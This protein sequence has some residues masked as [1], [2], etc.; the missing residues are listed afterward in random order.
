MTASEYSASRCPP[1]AAA[2]ISA[3]PDPRLPRQ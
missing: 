1:T 2:A 3:A